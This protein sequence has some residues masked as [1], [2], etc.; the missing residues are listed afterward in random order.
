MATFL[1][2]YFVRTNDTAERWQLDMNVNLSNVFIVV[3][4]KECYP[5]GNL[6]EVMRT[7]D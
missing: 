6:I 5:N 3:M 1:K 4:A 2:T 7:M